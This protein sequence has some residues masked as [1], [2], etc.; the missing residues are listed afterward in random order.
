MH[1]YLRVYARYQDAAHGKLSTYSEEY[2]TLKKENALCPHGEKCES[3]KNLSGHK[4]INSLLE[5]A[6]TVRVITS[7][8]V[9]RLIFDGFIH[10]P[11]YNYD[12]LFSS[13]QEAHQMGV[14]YA[15]PCEPSED[16]ARCLKGECDKCGLV[17][18]K[19]CGVLNAVHLKWEVRANADASATWIKKGDF[20]AREGQG[21]TFYAEMK[22]AYHKSMEHFQLK[23]EQ[24][25][26]QKVSLENLHASHP[27]EHL[28]TYSDV[29]GR[30]GVFGFH[31]SS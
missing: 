12:S 4:G 10:S 23:L 27:Y 22:T 13:K 30:G 16:K 25:S 1:K 5:N 26:R 19:W 20:V 21:E 6:L 18:Y 7:P 14:P 31:F 2:R 9:T 17:Q 3:Y 24:N 11:L 28:G 8:T 29:R 15:G